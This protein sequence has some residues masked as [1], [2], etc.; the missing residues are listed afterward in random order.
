M[1][2]TSRRTGAQQ[3]RRKVTVDHGEI[4]RALGRLEEGQTRL[5]QEVAEEKEHSNESRGRMH[6]KLERIEENVRIV[7]DVAA[8]ARDAVAEVTKTVV[9]DVK[10]QTDD[11]KR[12]RA[13]GKGT[14]WA[15]GIVAAGL[16][17][18]VA[19]VGEQIVNAIRGWLRII[20]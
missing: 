5:W 6:A 17:V 11:Y 8:Q 1:N 3:A 19:T 13:I 18:S 12:V 2:P 4:M 14:I 16:G 10:P 15:V 20:P 7:G 9:E